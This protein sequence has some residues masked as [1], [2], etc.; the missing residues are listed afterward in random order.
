ML[1]TDSRHRQGGPLRWLKR[2]QPDVERSRETTRRIIK[3]ETRATEIID[4]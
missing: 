1:P 4:P 3:D 2:D